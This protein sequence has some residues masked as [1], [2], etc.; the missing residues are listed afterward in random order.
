MELL[1]ARI[2]DR[3]V[4]AGLSESRLVAGIREDPHQAVSTEIRHH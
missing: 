1:G 3:S 2:G 4:E